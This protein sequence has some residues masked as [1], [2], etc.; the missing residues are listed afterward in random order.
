MSPTPQPRLRLAV[1]LGSVRQGRFGPVVAD[2]FLAE[3]RRDD[4]FQVDLI[5][6][7]DTALPIELPGP[8]PSTVP[9]GR[10]P[11]MRDLSEALAAADAYVVVTPEYN[12]SFPASVKSLIDWHYAEWRARPVGFVSYGG[13][14]GG[15]RAVEQLRPVF[16]EMHAV[17]VSEAVSFTRYWELFDGEGRL[18]EAEGHRGSATLMLDQLAWWAG[19]LHAAR[20]AVPYEVA[21]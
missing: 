8:D 7:A 16:S 12:H 14:A 13:A 5:D 1:I 6:L 19:A 10:P 15:L 4:R 17:T 21:G 18:T 9:A 2:W 11:G 20:E 3:A